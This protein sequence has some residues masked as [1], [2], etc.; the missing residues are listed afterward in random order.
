MAGRELRLSSRRSY[1]QMP[2]TYPSPQPFVAEIWSINGKR[3]DFRLSKLYH[4]SRPVGSAGA[5]ESCRGN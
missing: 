5:P 1:D 4:E 2:R 3:P